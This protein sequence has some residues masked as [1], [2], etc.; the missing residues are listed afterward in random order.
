MLAML[1]APVVTLAQGAPSL[2]PF[3]TV[4]QLTDAI[5]A[6]SAIMRSEDVESARGPSQAQWSQ[7]SDVLDSEWRYWLGAYEVAKS[8]R[9]TYEQVLASPSLTNDGRKFAQAQLTEARKKCDLLL[10]DRELLR[11]QRQMIISA[12]NKIGARLYGPKKD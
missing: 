8:D 2:A 5:R 1:A 10:A 6:E 4:E 3:P 12:T 7:Q 9:K 11:E